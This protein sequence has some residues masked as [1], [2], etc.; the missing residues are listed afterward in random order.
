[1]SS[2]IDNKRINIV[3]AIGIIAVVIG[4]YNGSWR[5]YFPPHLF[6]MPLFFMIGGVL[7]KDFFDINIIKKVFIKYFLYIV[8]TYILISLIVILLSKVFPLNAGT[9]FFTETISSLIFTPF[10]KNLHSSPYALVLWFLWAY[11]FVV[12]IGRYFIYIIKDK[13]TILMLGVILGYIGIAVLSPMYIKSKLWYFNT[14]TQIFVGI[15][16]YYI[17]YFIKDHLNKLKL[18]PLLLLSF[19]VYF[20]HKNG[21]FYGSGMSWSNYSGNPIMIM[22][23]T[24]ILC[25]FVFSISYYMVNFNILVKVGSYSKAIMSYHLLVFLLLTLIF[26]DNSFLIVNPLKNY[27]FRYSD[28]VYIGLGVSVP[29]LLGSVIDSFIKKLKLKDCVSNRFA[30]R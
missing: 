14:L 23:C 30:I 18:I 11:M 1:M 13:V 27:I 21:L 4:H 6:H 22:F 2:I 26:K 7:A 20:F 17:G 29:M 10:K 3:K 19:M 9:P 12:L 15:G 25:F 16:Y 5:E 24:S 28:L 8:Y